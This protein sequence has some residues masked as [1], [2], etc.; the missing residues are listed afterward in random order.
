M[1]ENEMVRLHHQLNGYG[2]DKT[3]GDNEGQGAW[4]AAWDHKE[5]DT[6]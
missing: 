1:T 6:T 3:L 2:F 4:H 5:L